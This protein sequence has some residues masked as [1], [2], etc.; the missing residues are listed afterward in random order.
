MDSPVRP[1]GLPEPGIA[2]MVLAFVR[3]KPDLPRSYLCLFVFA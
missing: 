1:A 2:D 3:L